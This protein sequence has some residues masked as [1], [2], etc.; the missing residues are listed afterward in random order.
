[1]LTDLKLAMMAYFFPPILAIAGG[2]FWTTFDGKLT[3]VKAFTTLAVAAV[4]INPMV[5]ILHAYPAMKGIA[6]CFKRIQTYLIL[7][8][9]QACQTGFETESDNGE[10]PNL[11]TLSDHDKRGSVISFSKAS[12]AP[13]TQIDPVL[14]N[15]S[16]TIQ[17]SLFTLLIGPVGSGKSTVLRAILGEATISEG[18]FWRRNQ[19][20]L[21]YCGQKAWL[22]NV[23][24]RANITAATPFE[25]VWYDEVTTAC[26]LMDD[27]KDLPGGKG[28]LTAAGSNGANLSG[29]QKHRVVSPSVF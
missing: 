26:C 23:S 29:G 15:V 6:A 13:A 2:L 9:V 17:P 28:D 21:A 24:I 14:R 11:D 4:I 10:K 12:I 27:F 25:R 22:R 3:A 20:Q 1:M 19:G 18:E 16:F 7:E 5:D 8:E